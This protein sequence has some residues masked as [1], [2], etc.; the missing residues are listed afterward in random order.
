M[1]G[2]R[3]DGAGRK[4]GSRNKRTQQAM[5]EAARGGILPLDVMLQAMRERFEAGD[6]KEAAAIAKDAA[7][8]VH[9][10]LASVQH[11]GDD[12]GPMQVQFVTLYES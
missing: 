6:F 5:D 3:R 9:P 10:R 8:Y 12:G 7:P 1:Q 4:A 2:G 11:A